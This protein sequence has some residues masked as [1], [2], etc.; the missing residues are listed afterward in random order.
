M[1]EL[2]C[3]TWGNAASPETLI[4]CLIPTGVYLFNPDAVPDYTFSQESLG[5]LF[6]TSTPK[7]HATPCATS[8]V[9][10]MTYFTQVFVLSQ[11]GY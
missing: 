7:E 9:D 8:A 11:E 3:K 1:L 10:E 4:S 5:L 6:Y 2:L